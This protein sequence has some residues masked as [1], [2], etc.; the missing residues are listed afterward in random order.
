MNHAVGRWLKVGVLTFVTAALVACAGAAGK[1][2]APGAPGE[3]G[4]P[5]ASASLPPLA[6]GTI[7]D[8]TL[9]ASGTSTV[10]LSAYF[11]E[12]EGEALTYAATSSA[13]AVATVAVSG[14]TLTVTAV[15]DGS[16]T[17]TVTATDA[18]SLTARQTFGV[19]VGAATTTT[20]PTTSDPTADSFK[21]EVG[22]KQDIAV[23]A[24]E[25]V[26]A[27]ETNVVAVQNSSTSWSL[28]AQKKGTHK[29]QVRRASDAVLVRTITLIAANR[30]PKR[31]TLEPPNRATL[32]EIAFT[33]D[34]P[35]GAT[36]LADYLRE[37]GK[38]RL[39]QLEDS[40]GPFDL[41]DY[42]TEPD[43]DPLTYTGKSGNSIVA[44]VNDVT[45]SGLVYVD[46]L[47]LDTFTF[48]ITFTATDND[49]D[50][51][52]GPALM[53]TVSSSDVLEQDYEVVQQDIQGNFEFAQVD[54]GFRSDAINR[55]VFE[56]GFL[57]A[58]A[59]DAATVGETNYRQ[60]T[61]AASLT[62]PPAAGESRY[63]L[64][65]SGPIKS[66][67]LEGATPGIADDEYSSNF[68]DDVDDGGTDHVVAIRGYGTYGT[69]KGND[70]D[71]LHDLRS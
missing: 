55:L 45:K 47:K 53:V 48:D 20:T 42:F 61:A 1:P 60:P 54:V 32:Q 15:A 6:V 7:E 66:V 52:S 33:T 35:A 25:V 62:S 28:T 30:A 27:D 68:T 49:S 31:T 36:V 64:S 21:V 9:Q 18:D 38:V 12:A 43:G 23:N 59:H 56:E 41:D 13:V 51:M 11:N 46:V 34:V 26:Y 67:L 39:Y 65:M 37:Y 16:A 63:T 10:D 58:D 14:S 3:P 24:D 17:I 70:H 22:K 19:T 57:F 2:G 29:V 4:Q 50:Q 8:M 71:H 44:V 40:D 69:R 5:G